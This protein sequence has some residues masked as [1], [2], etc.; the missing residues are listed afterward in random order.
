MNEPY[1][2]APEAKGVAVC[3]ARKQAYQHAVEDAFRKIV[4]IVLPN[5]KVSKVKIRH[6]DKGI[7]SPKYGQQLT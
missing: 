2:T 6:I 5:G 4:L 3:R 1:I 7:L